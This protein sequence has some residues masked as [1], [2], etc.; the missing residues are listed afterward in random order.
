MSQNKYQVVLSQEQRESLQAKIASGQARARELTHAHILL[1]ADRS[2]QGPGWKDEQIAEAF[3]VDRLT[4][5]R[6]RQR[7]VHEGQRAALRPRAARASKPTRLD[8]EGEAHL[9]A[10][11]CSPAPEGTEHGS[12]RRLSQ[13]LVALGIVDEIS[14]ETVRQ[15]LKKRHSNPGRSSNGVF[16]QRPMPLLSGT[17][18]TS[19][20]STS[21][22][23]IPSDR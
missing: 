11:A 12:L 13:R 21:A 1:K 20:K 17:W 5:L 3:E 22:P 7:F 4:V 8:G 10:L 15:V 9:I 16:P 2:G 6:V 23:T 18:R 19:C 14:H